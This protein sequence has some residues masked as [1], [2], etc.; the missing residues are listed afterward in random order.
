MVYELF[1]Y[2]PENSL[3]RLYTWTRLDYR[4]TGTR[5]NPGTY[6]LYGRHCG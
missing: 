1:F 2:H 3:T 4:T 6:R 5:Q